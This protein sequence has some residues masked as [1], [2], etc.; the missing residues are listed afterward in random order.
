MKNTNKKSDLMEIARLYWKWIKD[1]ELTRSP[2]TIRSYETTTGVYFEYLQEKKGIGK[3]NFSAE[4]CFSKDTILDWRKHLHEEK[5]CSPETCNVRLANL[6]SFLEYIGEADLKY[7]TLYVE[8]CNIKPMRCVKKKQHAIS[9]DVMDLIMQA[10]D[11]ESRS[12]CMDIMIL[13]FLY[14]TAV[15]IGEMRTVQIRDLHLEN[16]DPYVHIVGKGNK[17]RIVYIPEKVVENLNSFIRI[18]HGKNPDPD[19]FL[20]FSRVKGKSFPVTDSAIG[21]RLR[22]IEQKI[23]EQNPSLDCH[24]HAHAFRRTRATNLSDD[25]MN[26]FQISKILGHENLST[27]M[28]Y[29]DVSLS[30]KEASLMAIENDEDKSIK[31]KWPTDDESL[32]DLFK[33]HDNS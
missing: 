6:R 19:S 23:K 16:E 18:Y 33:R 30:K 24:V 9:D 2:H 8:S 1:C 22:I 17:E 5:K 32:K 4:A 14:G 12:G 27:T 25:G 28:C 15:R 13:S 31:P 7:L 21:K 26:V 10:P 20:F 11:A 29:V 3:N